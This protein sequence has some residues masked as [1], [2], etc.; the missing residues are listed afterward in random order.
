MSS[1]VTIISSSPL[2][3]GVFTFIAIMVTGGI[4]SKVDYV[5]FVYL[6]SDTLILSEPR[7]RVK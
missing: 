6:A 2:L 3:V 7:K 4:A 5:K 1:F